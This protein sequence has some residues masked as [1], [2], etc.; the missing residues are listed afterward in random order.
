MLTYYPFIYLAF[1]CPVV[2][3]SSKESDIIYI[4]TEIPSSLN[5]LYT[6][7]YRVST[8]YQVPVNNTGD[9]LN[10]PVSFIDRIFIERE[11]LYD[12]N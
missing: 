5:P 9:Y 12:D 2:F 1:Y 3:D 10:S 7:E 11:E 6:F 8:P 4:D